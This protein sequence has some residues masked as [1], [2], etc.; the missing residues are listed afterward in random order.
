[1]GK[2]AMRAFPLPDDPGPGNAIVRTTLSTVCGSDIHLVDEIPVPGGT[3]MG[4]EAVGVVEAVGAG[5]S[6]FAAGHRVAVSC[7]QCCGACARCREGNESVC[8]TFGAPANLVFGAQGEYFLVRGAETT[9]AR[10]PDAL[11]DEQVLLATDIMSTGFA[12]IER[13]GMQM[14]DTVAIF[15]QGPVGLCATAGARALG[16]GTIIAVEGIPER[17]A[18]AKR[19]GADV[20]VEPANAVV[21]IME[22]TGNV[23]VDIAVEALGH[24]QTFENCCAVTRLG[25]TVSSVGVYGAFPTLTLPTSGSFMHRKVVTTLCPVGTRRLERLMSLVASGKVDLTPLL[26]HSMKIADTP[27]AYDLFRSRD[28]GVLKIALRP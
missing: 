3:P 2:V 13:A 8:Q 7:L 12:A 26:T 4:H 10:I 11:A 23:G 15:A 24:Q 20:V 16:A 27:A 1:M 9:M 19:I 22:L 6:G 28:G 25:G 14:G 5:V 21:R 17:Q 18:M